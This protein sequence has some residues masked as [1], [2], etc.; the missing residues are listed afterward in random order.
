MKAIW[1]AQG[2]RYRHDEEFGVIGRKRI[3]IL[4]NFAY[5]VGRLLQC[6]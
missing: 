5:P 1:I 4:V 3:T 2:H 6:K